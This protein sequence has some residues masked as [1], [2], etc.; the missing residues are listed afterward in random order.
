[1]TDITSSTLP[2]R[3]ST[4]SRKFYIAAWRWHFYAGLYVAP[5]LIMLAVT[6][7]MMVW[8]SALLGRDG[9][10]IHAV[11]PGA[12]AVD[13]SRQAEAA[14]AA[15]P[16]GTVVQYIAPRTADGSALF[17]VNLGDQSTMVA[18][19]PYTGTALGDWTRR[20]ALY[21]LANVIH[22]TLL[23][24]DTGDRLIEIAA[25]F[26]VV[27]IVTGLFLWWPRD[28]KGP[29]S[30]LLPQFSARGRQLWKSLHMSI[31]FWCSAILLVFLLSGLSWAGIWGDRFTQAWSTF[32]A[33]KWDNV[34]LSDKTHGEHMNHD[35]MKEVAWTLEQTKMPVSGSK[36]GFDG[37][38]EG[39][40]VNLDTVVALARS[41]GFDG[42]F[43]LAFPGGADGVWTLSRD[44]MSND[45]DD[46][47]SDRT[48]HVDQYTGK[49]LADVGFADYGL[50]G[51]AMAVGIAFHEGDMGV[52]NLVLNTVFCLSIIFMSV[53]GFV[54]W[55]KR[56]PSGAARL[57][58]PALP[59]KLGLWKGGAIVMIAVALLFPLSGA[60][61]LV[62]L[63]VDMLLVRHIKPLKRVLS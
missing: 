38:A 27:L 60:V 63:A 45:S 19:D 6:G 51:K 35:G 43:Q 31:G 13:I 59:E 16:G 46:P 33:T 4:L 3:D 41:I 39:Q 36:A 20:D 23:L 22:G 34:P 5:F 10:K 18:V 17:R 15:V 57:V 12:Q 8:S 49:L 26:A 42:R 9:E 61:L 44:T 21:D 25:G 58:A 47:L 40:P 53:S 32:P 37:I 30:V 55:W 52:W 14:A 62:V 48:V 28:G 56:R 7:L 11:T 50:A 29:G 54:M 1:M 2:S 24:G